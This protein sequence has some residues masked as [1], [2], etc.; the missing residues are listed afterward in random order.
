VITDE[1]REHIVDGS[2][3]LGEVDEMARAL[4]G[5]QRLLRGGNED[6]HGMEVED[7]SLLSK[8]LHYIYI[9]GCW[10]E[11]SGYEVPRI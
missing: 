10:D 11:I 1:C 4:M 3:T 6:E 2:E 7:V 9:L 5:D 8:L